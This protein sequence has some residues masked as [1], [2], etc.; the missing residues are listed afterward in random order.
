[1][2][3]DRKNKLISKYMNINT[4]SEFIELFNNEIVKS[5]FKRDLDDYVNSLP[6]NQ[7]NI[8]TLRDV[9]NKVSLKLSTIYGS[10]LPESLSKLFPEKVKPF[11]ETSYDVTLTKL[12]DDK[13][14]QLNNF[15]TQL[16]QLLANLNGEIQKNVAEINR[17]EAFIKPYL[18]AQ[19]KIQS[20]ANKAIVS[21]IFKDKK[22]TTELKDFTKTLQTWNKVLPIYHQILKSSSPEDIEIVTIQNGSIDFVV[23]FD[24]NIALDLVEL[25]KI[26]FKCFMAYLSYKAMAKPLIESYFG[27]KILI[28]GEKEREKELINNIGAAIKRQI[29]EQHEKAIITDIK[30]DKNIDK[31]VEQ[32][33][34]LITNHILKGNDLKLLSLPENIEK[35][36]DKE[37]VKEEL[38]SISS[39]VRQAIKTIPAKEMKA[40]LENYTEQEG[41]E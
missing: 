11:T 38:R 19:T 12:I 28:E 37:L 32:V 40:L 24:F 4:L 2:G 35:G 16:H 29:I 13:E 8:V 18:T 6:N 30:I 17:I 14:I 39:E 22:T 33:V 21:I 23:N 26:G 25:F 31:K 34:H 27:N 15:F 1:M 7:S 10:D 3:K 5:G 36:A 20:D 9:A 41:Q